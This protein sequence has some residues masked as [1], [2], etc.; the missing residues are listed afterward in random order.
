MEKI[1]NVIWDMDDTFWTGTL[2]EQGGV[3][4][5]TENIQL[6]VHLADNGIMNSIVSK[7]NYD[8]V[9]CVL[10][11]NNI[12][13]YF[14]FP[15]INWNPKG[16]QVKQLLEDCSLRAVNALFI[17]DNEQNLN[18]VKYYNPEINIATPNK[19]SELWS[20]EGKPDP[21]HKRLK[22]Y[23][24][25]EL[26]KEN[27]LH[28]ASNEDF[29]VSS[30]IRCYIKRDCKEHK[31]R[32]LDLIN[33]SNQLN[34]T[35]VRSS[36]KELDKLLDDPE[37][38]CGYVE[39]EDD[40][41][42]YGIVGFFAIKG[43]FALHFLFS[44]RTIG[45]GIE[46]YVY[47]QLGYPNVQ[48]VG[49]IRTVLKTEDGPF[50]I[51]KTASK[52]ESPVY[53]KQPIKNKL[54]IYVT[55]GCDLEQLAAYLKP[56]DAKINY[57]FNIGI[58]RHDNTSLWKGTKIF[59]ELQKQEL[60]ANLPFVDTFSFDEGIYDERY[61]V[62]VMSIL[63]DY[64]QMLYLKKDESQIVIGHGDF[65]KP[66]NA[67]YI[68]EYFSKE[69]AEYFLD[70]FEPKGRIKPENLGENLKFIRENMNPNA[71]LI[72]INGSEVNLEHE[73]EEERFKVHQ[74]YNQVVDNFVRK[75]DNVLLLDIR[76]IVKSVE[77]VTDNIRHYR[78]DVYFEMA[79][80]L[81][82]LINDYTNG[83]LSSKN[84]NGLIWK[85]RRK[86]EQIKLKYWHG[87]LVE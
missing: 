76:R 27:A 18:E 60:I 10:E 35:K 25:L 61:N 21:Q 70:N 50:W 41:G 48:V 86:A 49:E 62:I 28:Y 8:D 33:R 65:N 68:P 87:F 29:L 63:M 78:R 44:C 3:Q 57:K 83:N 69:N 22:Q 42:E 14:I 71:L 15:C 79:E 82:K 17:D 53:D 75:Y 9:K 84:T 38:D 72:L 64:T 52:R 67:D 59:S 74:E 45:M 47:S 19:I 46:Q 32:L 77:Q 12:W 85:I 16:P 55:G 26:K 5:N 43:D 58:V 66:I 73:F 13:D 37:I 80:Q 31:E 54:N 81:A 40:F 30:N 56:G 4:L 2:S 7:N 1:K 36:A 51:N 34:Y 6:I 20:L 11:E 24:V 39:V 23:K